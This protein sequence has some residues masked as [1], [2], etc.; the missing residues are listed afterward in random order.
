MAEI[1]ARSVPGYGWILTLT[2]PDWQEQ[3]RSAAAWRRTSLLRA[4]PARTVVLVDWEVG[5]EP[6]RS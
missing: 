4:K 6:L 3:T 2:A 1:V 5:A